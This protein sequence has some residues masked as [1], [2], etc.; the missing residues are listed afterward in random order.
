MVLVGKDAVMYFIA[1]DVEEAVVGKGV[2]EEGAVDYDS[3]RYWDSE[4]FEGSCNN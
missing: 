4:D 2:A 1:Q 3:R